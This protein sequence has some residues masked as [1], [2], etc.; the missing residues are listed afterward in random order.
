MFVTKL[1]VYSIDFIMVLLYIRAMNPE[2]KPGRGITGRITSRRFW[3]AAAVSA[4]L[5]PPATHIGH[6]AFVVDAMSQR[7]ADCTYGIDPSNQWAYPFDAIVV[8]GTEPDGAENKMRLDAARI[9]YSKRLAPTIILLGQDD[10]S[11]TN[12]ATNMEELAQT[13]TQGNLRTV[14]VV[15]NAYHELR[16]TLLACANG[17]A[18]SSISAEALL[19][20]QDTQVIPTIN[21]LYSS[22]G[23][24]GTRLKETL[25]TLSLLWGHKGEIPTFFKRMIDGL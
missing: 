11:S 24:M 16:A 23:M 13:A 17:V 5:L 8:P 14:L 19:I 15:T 2:K 18:A 7:R 12:T 22:L 4:L 10:Y 25:G 20:N 9:A 1:S 21:E 3:L 6:T